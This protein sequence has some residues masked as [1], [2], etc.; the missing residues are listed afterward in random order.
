MYTESRK[1]TIKTHF[2]TDLTTERYSNTIENSFYRI[3][4]ELINNTLKH[5]QA[6]NIYIE[7]HELGQH[8]SLKY[9]DDGKGFDPEKPARGK[10]SGM[11]LSN[12]ISRAKSLDAKYELSTSPDNGFNFHINIPINQT[13]E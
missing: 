5:A 7:L 11:G 9:S 2:I 6:G 4:K 3:S 13:V 10:H 8:L 1:N 12:I